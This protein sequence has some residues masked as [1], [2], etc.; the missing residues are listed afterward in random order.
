MPA[1]KK[2][3]EGSTLSQEHG[4]KNARGCSASNQREEVRWSAGFPKLSCDMDGLNKLELVIRRK[5]EEMSGGEELSGRTGV[6]HKIAGP[7]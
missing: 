4:T 3:K 7:A 5:K 6:A 1:K 2:K